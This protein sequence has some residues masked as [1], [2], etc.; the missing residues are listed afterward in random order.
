MTITLVASI[1]GFQIEEPS[2]NFI[3]IL[4]LLGL[5][6][7]IKVTQRKAHFIDVYYKLEVINTLELNHK[8]YIIFERNTGFFNKYV[9]IWISLVEFGFYG[10]VCLSSIFLVERQPT[11][12][13]I[14][15]VILWLPLTLVVV[16]TGCG[17]ILTAVYFIYI[18]SLYL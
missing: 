3:R 10:L 9:L 4:Y 12:V 13:M 8:N 5:F 15:S 6:M 2:I 7:L 11:I 1:G 18:I 17:L 14:C 16:R